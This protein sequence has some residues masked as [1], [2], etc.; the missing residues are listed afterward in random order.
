[1]QAHNPIIVAMD[2]DFTL[3]EMVALAHDMKGHIGMAKIG[4]RLFTRHG[5]FGVRRIIEAGV[6]VFL[7]LKYHDIPNTVAA[8]VTEAA[9]LGVRMINVHASGGET[10]MRR[11]KE[12]LDDIVEETGLSRP[13]LIGVTV[14]TSLSDED[15]QA[16]GIMSPMAEQVERLAKLAKKAGL[17]GVVASP[18]EIGLIRQACGADF[19]IVTPGVRPAFL[20]VKGDDQKRVMTPQMAVSEG[21]NWLVIGRPV[22][23]ADDRK[24]AAKRILE[25]IEAK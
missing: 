16:V 10:M 24:E 17:D 5:A 25:E 13:L 7:D 6:D 12:A 9:L 23:Q 20:P 1:M 15:L 18:K 22:L 14:L 21:A 4:K 2:G 11:A 8:A 3:D 19:T